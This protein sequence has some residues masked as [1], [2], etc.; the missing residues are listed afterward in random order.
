MLMMIVMNIRKSCREPRFLYEPTRTQKTSHPF[1]NADSGLLDGKIGSNFSFFLI[2]HRSLGLAQAI[3][4]IK[5]LRTKSRSIRCETVDAPIVHRHVAEKLG[6]PAISTE[7]LLPFLL[8]LPSL[9]IRIL[10]QKMMFIFLNGCQDTLRLRKR[11]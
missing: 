11:K 8:M 6:I 3:S 5:W 1:L 7:S 10:Q 9:G 2:E 4:G